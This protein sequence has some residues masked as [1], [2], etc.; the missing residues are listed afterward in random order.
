MKLTKRVGKDWVMDVKYEKY[1][2]R[3]N[4][5][6]SNGTPGLAPFHARSYQL[7]VTYYF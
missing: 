5:A 6:L 1:E 4:W 2:Q 3:S 7:G